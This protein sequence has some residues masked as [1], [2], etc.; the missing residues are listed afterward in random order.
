MEGGGKET[1]E[2]LFVI[3][4]RRS[5]FDS[6]RKNYFEDSNINLFEGAK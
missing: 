4:Y 5:V 6:R 1:A 3:K 2:T